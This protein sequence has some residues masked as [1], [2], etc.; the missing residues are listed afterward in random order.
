[1]KQHSL[2]IRNNL[3]KTIK[4]FTGKVM[5]QMISVIAKLERNL[6]ADR[7]VKKSKLVKNVEERLNVL[8]YHKRN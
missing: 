4:I 8:R 6:L 3:K 5:L 1:M 2:S 7:F